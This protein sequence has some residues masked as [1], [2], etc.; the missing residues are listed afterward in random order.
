MLL[1]LPLSVSAGINRL[2]GL[3]SKIL[4]SMA[5]MKHN[6]SNALVIVGV[7]VGSVQ[8]FLVGIEFPRGAF[9]PNAT[10]SACDWSVAARARLRRTLPW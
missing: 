5:P 3:G 8:F 10:P 2:K 4:A 6:R 7:V 1:V 9:K